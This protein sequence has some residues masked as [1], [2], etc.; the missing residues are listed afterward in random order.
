MHRNKTI[1]LQRKLYDVQVEL[2]KTR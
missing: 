2:N 1:V